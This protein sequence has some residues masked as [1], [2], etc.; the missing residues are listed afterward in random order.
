MKRSVLAGWSA[1]PCLLLALALR[2]EAQ[3]KPVMSSKDRTDTVRITVTGEVDLEYVWR[4]E[5]ITTFTGGVSQ[6]PP[7]ASVGSEN[8]VQG[9]AAVRLNAELSDKVTA[10]VELGTKEAD[11]GTLNTF[12]GG[13]ALPLK[14]REG[15]VLVQELFMP[16]LQLQLGISTWGFDVRGKG[17]SMAFDLRHAQSFW[18]NA[19]PGPDTDVT[20]GAR[21]GDYQEPEPVGAWLRYG[22]EKLVIDVVA[23]PAVFEAGSPH[24]DESF[25]AAD[26]FYKI[27][28]KD[29]RIGAIVAAIAGPNGG[30]LV[31]AYGGG[32][33][34]KGYQT[35]DVYG[36]IYFENGKSGIGGVTPSVTVGAYAYQFGVEYVVPGDSKS[37]VGANM[38]YFSG[39]SEAN[40]HCSSFLSYENMH[41]LMIIEDMYLG[42]DWDTNYRAFKFAGGFS[43]NAGGKANLRISAI[44]GLCQ[45]ARSVQFTA[46]P[47]PE[48]TRK[49][50]NEGDLR[51]DWD[52]TKQLTLSAGVAYLW[53][54]KVLEDS[55]GGPDAPNASQHTLLFT[56]GTDVK[57]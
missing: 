35:F 10:V 20:L 52:F 48:N 37:W 29:S 43:L 30:T 26:L 23:L 21:A 39:D 42:F 8:S 45:T 12:G 50:G 40:N 2:A 3:D 17:E 14:L 19:K 28:D 18:R 47:N 32:F 49:L 56:V 11:G 46:I 38:T 25:Y 7:P 57:F 34:W 1:A 51:V 5:E 53:G 4:R 55:M 41:D 54:S 33:D 44:V 27:D 31:Y 15:N 9:F 24:N 22:R 36:E 6:A 13:T 16:E